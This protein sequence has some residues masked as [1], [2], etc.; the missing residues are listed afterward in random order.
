M[1]SKIS[2]GEDRIHG[3]VTIAYNIA[4]V[5]QI[6]QENGVIFLHGA[7]QDHAYSL[8]SLHCPDTYLCFALM[9]APQVWTAHATPTTACSSVYN[10][11]YIGT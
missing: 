2:E 11:T 8:V 7:A 4:T 10:C 3:C 5:D 1:Y 9:L 6:F